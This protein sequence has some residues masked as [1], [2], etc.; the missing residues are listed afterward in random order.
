MK[1]VK[2][3][4]YFSIALL[5]FN[6]CTGK[7]ESTIQE[8]NLI[9]ITNQQFSTD[10]MLLGEVENIPFENVVKCNGTI[11]PQPNGIAR[12][13]AP[14]AGV[15]KNIHIQNGQL[16][17][18]NQS[19]LVITGNEIIDL[20][21]DFAEASANYARSK[22]EFER[23]KSLFSEKVTSEKEFI[24]ADSEYKSAMAKYNG[25]KMKIQA[26]GL[27]LSNIE[28][29][30]FY[31]SYTIRTP[32]NGTISNL[33]ANIG[34]YIDSQTDLMEIIDPT[35]L[36]LRLSVFSSDMAQLKPGQKVRF[37]SASSIEM[38]YA[39][40][41]SI[42]VSINEESRTIECHASILDKSAV[43]PIANTFVES[44]IIT[45]IDTVQALP[46]EAIIKTETGYVVL[47]LEKQ[48]KEIYFFK[49]TDVRIGRQHKGY[50][51]VLTDIG[52]SKIITKGVYNIQL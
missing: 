24:L 49:K 27:S 8:T 43:N 21:R 15:I 47:M 50:T 30:E 22:N 41:V 52:N 17:R 3:L 34:S 48:E 4:L 1:T 19:L 33:K 45:R 32:I 9:E 6:S 42:G 29:G 38:C 39:S 36:Q 37:E 18:S 12:I 25:L 13:S 20:Q 2:S 14:V 40:L 11:V 51:E 35:R 26:V 31:S 5:F 46:N 7:Q 44:E 16:V 23:S 10:N 28:N